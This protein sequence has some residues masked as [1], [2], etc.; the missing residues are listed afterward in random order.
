MQAATRE[1]K[2]LTLFPGKL[3]DT[4]PGG[5]FRRASVSDAVR[6]GVTIREQDQYNGSYVNKFEHKF[7]TVSRENSYLM[8]FFTAG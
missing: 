3:R 6:C 2:I 1:I 8:A 7:N 4:G 5:S